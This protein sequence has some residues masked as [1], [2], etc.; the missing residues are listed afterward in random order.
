VQRWG[1]GQRTCSAARVN[2]YLP[3]LRA[4]FQRAY[5][6]RDPITRDRAVEEVPVIK[7]LPE[8]KRKARPVPES[9]L[10]RLHEILPA[11]VLDGMV[12]TLYFGFRR[13]EAFRLQEHQVD[14]HT[15][16]VRL[17]GESVK[18][19]EDVFLP[20]S[21]FA[22]GYLRAL[23]IEADH[24]RTRFLIT[25]RPAKTAKAA[26]DALRW[27]PIR[28][29][30]TAWRTAMKI[31]EVELG[32]KWRWHDVRAAII[33]HVAINSGPLAAQRLASHSDFKTTQGYIE[34][35]DQVM[36]DA[37]EKAS[38]RPA[39]GTVRGGKL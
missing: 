37:V 20:A 11:H 35:A 25:W 3:L 39:F 5:N 32:A 22:L 1:E 8:T 18:D 12:L 23:A 26:Q 21:Q 9:A 30:K 17:Q 33:T 24:R 16:G 15:E 29:P 27:R 38:D 36:R 4:A 14:W 19:D 7:D 10:A 34:V 2:R 28:S 13:G 6:T 31:V